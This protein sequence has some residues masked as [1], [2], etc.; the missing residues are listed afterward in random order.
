MV[1]ENVLACALLTSM[2]SILDQLEQA[3]GASFTISWIRD[4]L[5]VEVGLQSNH[6]DIIICDPHIGRI[7]LESLVQVC[8]KLHPR[9]PL[10]FISKPSD[11]AFSRW[12]FQK[13]ITNL[14]EVPFVHEDIAFKIDLALKVKARIEKGGLT[15]QEIG[16]VYNLLKTYYY[17][18]ENILQYIKNSNLSLTVV[19]AELDKKARFGSCIFDHIPRYGQIDDAV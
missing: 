16:H 5:D 7:E 11:D 10:F 8:Q 13:G 9:A 6:L 18:L 15:E 17:D 19:Q 12:A 14:I 4:G 3:L 2:P 1:Q